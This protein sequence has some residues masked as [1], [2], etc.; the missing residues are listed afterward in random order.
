MAA[1]VGALPRI[2][3]DLLIFTLIHEAKQGF[4]C[5]EW[6]ENTKVTPI[7]QNWSQTQWKGLDIKS[8]IAV[9]VDVFNRRLVTQ[10]PKVA[11]SIWLDTAQQES[12]ILIYFVLKHIL[13]RFSIHISIML[14]RNLQTVSFSMLGHFTVRVISCIEFI[15]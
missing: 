3:I 8:D 9:N 15:L 4:G 6:D 11:T 5:V 10:L 1:L 14:D 13:I 12:F 2:I 7:G